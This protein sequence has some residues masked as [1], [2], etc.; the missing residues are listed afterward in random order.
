MRNPGAPD[1]I[2]L[3][4]YFTGEQVA[5]ADAYRNPRYPVVFATMGL[6]ILALAIM[7]LGPG[8]RRLGAWSASATGDRWWLQALLLVLVV[9][10]VPA[11]LTLPASIW[12]WRHDRAFGLATNTLPAHLSDVAKATGFELAIGAIAAV[13]FVGIARALPRGWP[14][15]VAAGGV[16]LTVVL[17]YLFPLVYEP[18]FNRFEHLEGPGRDRI[19][20]LAARA[21]VRVDDVLVSDASR[22][23]T[24]VNAYVSGLGS[25]KRVVLYDTLLADTPA[26]EV[27]AVVAH[28]LAHVKH[29][30][31][32]RGT[33]LGAAGVVAGVLVLWGLFSA[34]GLRRWLG[35]GGPGDPAVIAFVAFFIA[36]ATLLTMPVQNAVSRSMEA[37]ADRTGIELTG[38]PE[39]AI[40][41]EVKL[42]VENLS[43]LNPNPFIAWMFYTHP[44][45]LE[46]IDI[47]RA[48]SARSEG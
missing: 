4:D 26:R 12:S 21:G 11:I 7:G 10:V 2:R 46:R 48:A 37:G 34:A 41:L 1:G 17:V 20:A 6:S 18:A 30:D 28:E 5:R 25:T 15:A 9:V 13:A 35:I 47:A 42:A 44:P 45:V 24:R 27:D 39:A 16:A 29:N 32:L 38:D 31:V 40:G 14:A 22:R 36:A 43:D 33:L 3:E 19:V 8:S 23:T